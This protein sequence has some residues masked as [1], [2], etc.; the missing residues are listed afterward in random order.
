MGELSLTADVS[1]SAEAVELALVVTGDGR[2]ALRRGHDRGGTVGLIFRSENHGR[3]GGQ[4]YRAM[5]QAASAR[6]EMWKGEGG[7]MI[8]ATVVA[9]SIE[10]IGVAAASAVLFP[11]YEVPAVRVVPGEGVL[12]F[13]GQWLQGIA[14]K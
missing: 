13:V 9:A 5:T 11:G 3:S 7:R 10:C 1:D 12:R 4:M 6:K 8:T 14:E 2:S